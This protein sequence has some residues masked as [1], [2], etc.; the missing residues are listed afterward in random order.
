MQIFATIPMNLHFC[1]F[2]CIFFDMDLKL[3]P[4]AVAWIGRDTVGFPLLHRLI[5]GMPSLCDYH[6]NAK[7]AVAKREIEEC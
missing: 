2:H 7:L 4:H 1:H 6:G 3:M 5:R